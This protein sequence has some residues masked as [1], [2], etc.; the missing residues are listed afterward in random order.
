MRAFF[1][2]GGRLIDSSPMYG[3]SQEVVGYG[4]ASSAGRRTLFCGRQG[5]DR[6]RRRTGRRRSRNRA[7]TGA[8]A[9][10]TC[11][12]CTTCWHGRSTCPALLAMKAAG[13]VRYVGI[14]TSEGRR[15]DEIEQIM[16]SRPIDFVQVTYNVLDREVER[17]ILPLAQDRG[18]AVIAQPAVPAGRAHPRRW[19]RHPLPA[20]GRRDRRGHLGS[21]PAQV[22][23]LP[24]RDHLRHSGDHQARARAW[25]TSRAADRRRCP[26]RPCGGAWR[27][28]V[29]RL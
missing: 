4:L 28:H 12:R 1:Q 11:C 17:R 19:T 23:H 9:G 16:A 26:M 20:L 10:S 15:H 6:L 2:A 21:A 8:S 13:R 3:S 29:E 14:T 18:I 27:T 25:R 5:L 24:S 7:R 22:H